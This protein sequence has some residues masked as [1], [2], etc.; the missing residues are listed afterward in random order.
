MLLI[1]AMLPTDSR[2]LVLEEPRQQSKTCTQETYNKMLFS[3]FAGNVLNHFYECHNHCKMK[4][5]GEINSVLEE[6]LKG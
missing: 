6:M 3:L 2:A 4:T 1:V 5:T